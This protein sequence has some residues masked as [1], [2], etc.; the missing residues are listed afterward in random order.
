MFLLGETNRAL[1]KD[2]G[3]EWIREIGIDVRRDDKEG[4]KQD[5]GRLGQYSRD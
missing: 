4:S 2:R 3:E 1:V 5:S